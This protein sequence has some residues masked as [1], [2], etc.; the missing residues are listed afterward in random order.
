MVMGYVDMA[1]GYAVM[2]VEFIDTL[3]DMIPI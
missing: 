2:G 3:R 1:L